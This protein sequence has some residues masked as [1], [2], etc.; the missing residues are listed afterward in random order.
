MIEQTNPKVLR[1]ISIK[2]FETIEEITLPEVAQGNNIKSLSEVN[3]IVVF[4][5]LGEADLF[6][7]NSKRQT[8]RIKSH[9]EQIN[10][11]IRY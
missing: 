4:A 10:K 2:K 5:V 8:I 3:G 1:K 11:V 9:I 7:I 6:F